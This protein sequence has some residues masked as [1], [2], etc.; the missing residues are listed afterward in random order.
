M[1][2]NIHEWRKKDGVVR[3]AST[4]IMCIMR[5]QIR[6]EVERV[7]SVLE[8]VYTLFG[9]RVNRKILDITGWNCHFFLKGIYKNEP[10]LL[11]PWVIAGN[12]MK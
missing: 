3:F 5:T 9:W 1:N 6:S 11:R 10:V 12:K 7:C 8:H 4:L 2:V